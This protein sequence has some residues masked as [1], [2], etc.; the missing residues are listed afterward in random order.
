MRSVKLGSTGES[1]SEMCLGTM[2][3]GD[4]CDE[5]ES[6]R[7]LATAIDQGVSFVDTAAVY[8]EGH[9][10]E[11]LGRILKGR[12]DK[13]FLVTKVHKGVDGKSIRDSID[14]S[15]TRLQTD[16][17]DLYLIHWPKPGMRP[18]EIMEALN[19]VVEQ[20]KARY[21]GCSNFPAWLYAH[22]N[23]IAE[24]NGWAAFVCNQIPYSLLERG[25]EV[26]VLPQA[27]A[28]GIAITT[29]RPLVMGLLAGK[30]VPGQ[31]IPSDARAQTDPR[32]PAWLDKYGEG[33]LSLLRFAETRGLHPAQV[34]I[35]WVRHSPAVTAP[36]VGIS[37]LKQLDA[38]VTAFSVDLTDEEYARVTG[39][40][41]TAVKEGPGGTFPE[42][43]QA[44]DLVRQFRNL[45]H[46]TQLQSP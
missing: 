1:V 43:R 14:E 7:I 42:V 36:I 21:V 26:E 10:E 15:L 9:T 45:S 3:F 18:V 34:A 25:A 20:G 41:D 4:R 33:I 11:I 23:A 31:P 24:R 37:S 2:M 32:L 17:V 40:F 35:S 5:A 27:I 13:L 16:Y 8:S 12:R 44:L 29:Y 22:S 39:F 30:Y 19:N 6:D 28:E 46:E 38:I